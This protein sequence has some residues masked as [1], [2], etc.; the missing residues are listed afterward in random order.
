ME[1]PLKI[2]FR[3]M[4]P[5]K[6]I[7]NTIRERAAKLE[8]LHDGITACRVNLEAPHRHHHKGKSYVVRIDITV[9]VVSW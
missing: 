3:D 2:T 4:P 6:A 1:I 5:S 9:P 7:E 8:S